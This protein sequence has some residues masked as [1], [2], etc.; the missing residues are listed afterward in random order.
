MRFQNGQGIS[1]LF[2]IFCVFHCATIS[3]SAISEKIDD[4]CD[5][6]DLEAK[7]A[8]LAHQASEDAK[9]CYFSL[10]SFLISKVN[11]EKGTTNRNRLTIWISV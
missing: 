11:F 9:R 8:Q 3:V 4:E 5:E 1:F 2:H 7:K 10:I 6:V